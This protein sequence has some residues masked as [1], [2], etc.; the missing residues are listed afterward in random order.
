M[1]ARYT[2]AACACVALAACDPRVSLDVRQRLL[3]SP[4]TDC[5]GSALTSA[6]GVMETTRLK[7]GYG[8]DIFWVTL[9]DSTA[10][11]GQRT[12]TVTRLAPPDSGG[13]VEVHF[14]WAGLR[15]PSKA[16]E[17]AAVSVGNQLLAHLRNACAPNTSTPVECDYHDGHVWRCEQ[18]V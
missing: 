11:G 10:K 1:N 2:A 12:V 13:K 18:A 3:P 5:L 6:P 9:R 14:V 15:R 7:S 8:Q 4:S 17:R 16:K